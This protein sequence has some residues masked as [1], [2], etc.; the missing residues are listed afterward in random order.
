MGF[1][2]KPRFLIS[3]FG[4]A[5]CVLYFAF[6]GFA[7]DIKE[8][9]VAGS[10][11]PDNPQELSV[12]IDGFLEKANPQPVSGEIF[13]FISPHA[14]Y[15]YSGQVAAY[16]YRL[17]KD[18]PY[19]TVIIIA[20][21]HNPDFSSVSVYKEG[22]FRTPLGD[23]AVDSEVAQK[24][25]N[26]YPEI[27]FEPLVFEKEHS[28]E[29]QLPFLQ[30]TLS[31][32]KIV[33]IIVGDCDLE[34]CHK[35]AGLLK[36]AVAGRKDILIAASTDLYHGYDYETAD[37]IDSL[38]LAYLGNMDA[39]GLYSGLKQGRLQACGSFA[40]V[41][42]LLLA[43]ELGHTKLTVLR[44]TNSAE[45]TGK[46]VKGIWTVG[47]ASCVIDKEEGAG[48]MLNQNQKKRLLEIARSSIENYLKTGKKPELNE[49]DPV[50]LREMGAFVTLHKQ[51]R[52]QGCIGNLE[53][54]QPL[55]LTIRDM[56][57]EAAVGDPR[58]IPLKLAGLK[59]IDI[60]ISVLSPLE[61]IDSVDKIEMGKH[62]VLVRRG[63]NQGVY[64]PQVAIETGWS[65][66]EFLSSLCAEKAGLPAEAWKD[67]STEIY[68]FSAD[69]FSEKEL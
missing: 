18:K 35:L 1:G 24:L 6:S 10:F 68:I 25:L 15:G 57:I 56:A 28:L 44:H 47:Y 2:A 61:K 62:G 43:K 54:R 45:V 58:F 39:E 26:R 64:L 14:G 23:I 67:K 46:K 37:I 32:F 17:I 31:G 55:Y 8:P 12:M 41:S 36:E 3:S 53:G 51:G 22:V 49:Q 16:G 4:F 48:T 34:T 5:L 38:T 52:L 63:F 21:S 7:A 33:P 65:K 9:N 69:V 59:E 13:A 50:L 40:I 27:I 29:V 42:T 60:E 11:Y 20:G 19:R 30:R 66:E